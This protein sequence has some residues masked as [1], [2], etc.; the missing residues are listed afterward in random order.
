M[1]HSVIVF[2]Q[3]AASDVPGEWLS[4]WENLKRFAA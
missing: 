3:E 1:P 2:I 4:L